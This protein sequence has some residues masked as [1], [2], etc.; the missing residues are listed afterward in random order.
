MVPH[1][2]IKNFIRMVLKIMY[3]FLLFAFFVATASYS[4]ILRYSY[5]K[6]SYFQTLLCLG[7]NSK[8]VY[9][10]EWSDN[11]SD[12]YYESGYYEKIDDTIF[13]YVRNI[14]LDNLMNFS[15]TRKAV[16]NGSHLILLR[17]NNTVFLRMRRKYLAKNRCKLVI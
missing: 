9:S 11:S 1:I 2:H 5:N 7:D 6:K 16:I 15:F 3:F 10:E 13:L 12:K 8:F 14:G 4:Q 17:D